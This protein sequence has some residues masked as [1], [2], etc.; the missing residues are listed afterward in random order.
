MEPLAG[1]VLTPNLIPDEPVEVG[2]EYDFPL[3]RAFA[4]ARWAPA[5]L[6]SRKASP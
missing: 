4:A 1:V 5:G 2:S 3:F 6:P